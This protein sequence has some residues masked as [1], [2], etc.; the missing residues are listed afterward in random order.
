M[1]TSFVCPQEDL[2]L[3]TNVLINTYMS[4]CNYII[5]WCKQFIKYLSPSG[6]CLAFILDKLLKH[7]SDYQNCCWLNFCPSTNLL[8]VTLSLF[9]TAHVGVSV[10][11]EI[12]TKGPENVAAHNFHLFEQLCSVWTQRGKEEEVH[13]FFCVSW[14]LSKLMP[15]WWKHFTL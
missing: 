4:A 10:C 7:L 2:Q 8:T 6:S 5:V 12:L 1:K 3:L 13:K 15:A 11:V 14:D 9:S